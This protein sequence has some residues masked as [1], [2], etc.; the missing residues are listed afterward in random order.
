MINPQFWPSTNGY[1]PVVF[2]GEL[3]LCEACEEEPY[4]P[5]HD[6]HYADCT[7]IGPTQDGVDYKEVDG[8]L[9][10]RVEA[11]DVSLSCDGETQAG[12]PLPHSGTS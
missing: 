5:I 3:P 7:C 1:Q 10:G 4:C 6:M 9:Y 12:N 11:E 8:V 2:A